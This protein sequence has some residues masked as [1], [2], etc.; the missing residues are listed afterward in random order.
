MKVKCKLCKQNIKDID[1]K[2]VESLKNF[3]DPMYKIM[4][5]TRTKLCQKHQKRI[6]TAIKKS[7]IAGLMPFTHQ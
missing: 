4:P 2:D 7:R 5:R 6:A 3:I 1:Y